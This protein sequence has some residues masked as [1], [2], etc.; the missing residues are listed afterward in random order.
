MPL[1]FSYGTLQQKNVQVSTFGRVLQGHKDELLGFEQSFVKIEDPQVAAASGKT[2]HANV[3]FNGR[4]DSRV[5]GTVFE[6]SDAELAAADQYEQLAA[7][8]RI[9]GMLASG[10]QAWVY[11]DARSA[12]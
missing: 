12:L 6:I 8:K 9:N 3:T 4:N 11:V 1:L 2:H 10:N 7:Y 5:S